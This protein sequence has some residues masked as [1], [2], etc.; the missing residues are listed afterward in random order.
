VAFLHFSKIA[1]STA[2]LAREMFTVTRWTTMPPRFFVSYLVVS[3]APKSEQCLTLT[4]NKKLLNTIKKKHF[5]KK[6]RVKF[7]R[8]E[9][10]SG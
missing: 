9:N 10:T 8:W 1:L 5:E 7:E 4:E 3:T 6:Y 2:T